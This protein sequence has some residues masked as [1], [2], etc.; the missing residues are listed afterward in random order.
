MPLAAVTFTRCRRVER[1]VKGRNE[2]QIPR[3]GRAVGEPSPTLHNFFDFEISYS[4]E[5]ISRAK[6]S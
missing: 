3:V 4:V 6:S 1:V 2:L 5:S